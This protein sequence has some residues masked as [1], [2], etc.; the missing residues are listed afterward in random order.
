MPI[1]TV[2]STEFRQKVG[3]YIDAAGK[4]SVIITKHS[5]PSRVLVDFK[6][7]ERLKEYDTRRALYPHEF[8]EETKARLEEGYQGEKT[9][10]LDHLID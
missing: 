4:E 10:H 3:Q 8:G 2:T 5:R 6:F 7:Y 9:P 1:K